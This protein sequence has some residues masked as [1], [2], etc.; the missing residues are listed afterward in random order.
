MQPGGHLDNSLFA[1][2]VTGTNTLAF[3]CGWTHTQYSMNQFFSST[4]K[5]L[6]TY[7]FLPLFIPHKLLL[8]QLETA[9]PVQQWRTS[10]VKA[11]C[12]FNNNSISM[13]PF[14]IPI[15]PRL[16]GAGAYLACSGQES[17][18]LERSSVLHRTPMINYKK[19]NFM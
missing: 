9:L 18:A 10:T 1:F 2:F 13:C 4:L 7:P 17:G 8:L 5:S 11:G 3:R 12:M 15:Q 16:I 14:S 6:T 19:N